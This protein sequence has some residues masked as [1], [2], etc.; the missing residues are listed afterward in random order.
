MCS[1]SACSR[2]RVLETEEEALVRPH[3]PGR[4]SSFPPTMAAT[5]PRFL[6]LHTPRSSPP[7]RLRGRLDHRTRM[8]PSFLLFFLKRWR[9]VLFSSSSSFENTFSSSSFLFLKRNGAK[10]CR[11]PQQ[12]PT[13]WATAR[14]RRAT[15][16]ARM[17][18]SLFRFEFKKDIQTTP[19]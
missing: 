2:C 10:P 13:T 7:L 9:Q 6:H 19:N 11:P 18:V 15:R 12:Q 4:W 14:R 1:S 8:V 5:I 16:R 3:V 17:I